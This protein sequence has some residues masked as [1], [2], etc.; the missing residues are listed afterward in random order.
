MFSLRHDFI[1]AAVI[2]A[3]APTTGV[4]QTSLDESLQPYLVR[5]ELPAVA[6]AVVHDGR[7]VAS[8][9]V[10]TR[11]AGAAIPVT[12]HDRWHLG[13]NGKAMTSLLA[14]ILV[15]EGKLKWTSTLPDV[16]PELADKITPEL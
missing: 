7:V 3:G 13:S 4:A 2:L 9:A 10:G 16:F 12:I 15:D 11:K 5:Y 8:G 1:L 14:A 6:A